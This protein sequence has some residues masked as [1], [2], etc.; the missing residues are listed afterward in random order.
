MNLHP[1]SF[2]KLLETARDLENPAQIREMIASLQ[3]LEKNIRFMRQRLMG[4]LSQLERLGEE[5][6]QKQ[7]ESLKASLQVLTSQKAIG[8]K[9]EE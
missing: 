6:R 3:L 4:Q 7:R 2:E 9:E 8:S 1:L 5:A